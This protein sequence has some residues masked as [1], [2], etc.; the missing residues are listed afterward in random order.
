MVRVR[1]N[2][3]TSARSFR[4]AN[5]RILSRGEIADVPIEAIQDDKPARAIIERIKDD[6]STVGRK[7]ILRVFLPRPGIGDIHWV[8][9]KL[10]ALLARHG[11][12][13]ADVQ[14]A[15]ESGRPERRS[16]QFLEANPLIRIVEY[17][18]SPAKSL[19]EPGVVVGGATDRWDYALDAT[20][21][22]NAGKNL[23]A[24][25]LPGLDTDW[26]YLLNYD[27]FA[28]RIYENERR[29]AVCLSMLDGNHLNWGT[30][31]HEAEW[32]WLANLLAEYV[33]PV[34]VGL[35]CDWAWADKIHRSGGHLSNAVGSTESFFDIIPLLRQSHGIIGTCSG[36][37]MIAAAGGIPTIILWPIGFKKE[38]WHNWIHS[39]AP[40]Y[41]PVSCEASPPE[42]L[43]LAKRLF[44]LRK[45]GDGKRRQ[46]ISEGSPAK[47]SEQPEEVAD[48]RGVDA[49]QVETIRR[50]AASR[51]KSFEQVCER[52]GVSDIR[53]MTVEQFG[54]AKLWLTKLKRAAGAGR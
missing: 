33:L 31:W 5:G 26:N 39:D 7:K 52:Y 12:Q 3:K 23:D 38:C 6:L 46:G 21:Q 24:E 27:V 13:Q 11:A 44:G 32:A 25:F 8:F 53:G 4:L 43:E 30:Y 45:K 41:A 2:E 48:D 22:F 20:S 47:D 18:A 35:K 15:T 10:R 40:N 19:P 36:L 42:V 28:R 17:V 54:Q 37:T 9:L 1:I 29:E 14:I 16:Q 49:D 51:G 34:G 50:L